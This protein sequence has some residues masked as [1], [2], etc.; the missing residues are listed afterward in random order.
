MQSRITSKLSHW[1][2]GPQKT[3]VAS[4]HYDGELCFNMAREFAGKIMPYVLLRIRGCGAH[5]ENG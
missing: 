3:D 4:F 2:L 5:S 1:G